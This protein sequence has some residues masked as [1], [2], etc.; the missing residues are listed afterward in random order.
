M[1]FFVEGKISH[2]DER[3]GR[4]MALSP[5]LSGAALCEGRAEHFTTTKLSGNMFLYQLASLKA[6]F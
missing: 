2:E 5:L 3:Q 1:A 4:Q 6:L